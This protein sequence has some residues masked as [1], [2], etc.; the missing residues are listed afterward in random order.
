MESRKKNGL[1]DTV[2]SNIENHDK[3]KALDDDEII[4]HRVI[5]FRDAPEEETEE[6]INDEDFLKEMDV[7]DAWEG[8]EDRLK[9]DLKRKSRPR[10][11][12]KRLTSR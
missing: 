1:N 5:R 9:E 6:Y 11:R 12:E 2:S 3:S 4:V 7:V 8:D 10:D